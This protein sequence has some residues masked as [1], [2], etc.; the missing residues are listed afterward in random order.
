MGADGL[1]PSICVRAHAVQLSG[2]I[3]KQISNVAVLRQF[4]VEVNSLTGGI[5]PELGSMPSMVRGW[6][7][8]YSTWLSHVSPYVY[9]Q[10]AFGGGC[11]AWHDRLRHGHWHCSVVAKHPTAQRF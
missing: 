5:P 4:K 11:A 8:L 9:M 7:Y 1:T 6:S 2:P 10:H 3:P